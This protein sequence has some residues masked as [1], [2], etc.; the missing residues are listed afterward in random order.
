MDKLRI[1]ILNTYTREA[2]D[3]FPSLSTS[4][5]KKM[6]KRTSKSNQGNLGGHGSARGIG[7][8]L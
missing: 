1:G 2:R 3:L 8:R 4:H 7:R 6:E 5:L